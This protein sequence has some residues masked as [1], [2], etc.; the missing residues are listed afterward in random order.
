MRFIT[1]LLYVRVARKTKIIL[2]YY[3]L[4]AIR[5]HIMDYIQRIF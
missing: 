4:I 3:A 1:L 2:F 5:W